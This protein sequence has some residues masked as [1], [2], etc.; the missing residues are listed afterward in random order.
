MKKKIVIIGGGIGGLSAGIY[1]LKAGYDA[2][3]YEK[4]PV[5]GGECMGWNRK[6]YHID[7]CIHWLT[8]TDEKTDLWKVWN[9]LGAIDENTAYVD[10]GKFY[11]SIL[12]GK[13]L[14]L[15]NDLEKTRNELIAFAPEDKKKILDILYPGREEKS[16]EETFFKRNAAINRRIKA[17][18]EETGEKICYKVIY[19][20]QYKQL[21]NTTLEFAVFRTREG[22]YNVVFLESQK[23]AIEA[24]LRGNAPTAHNRKLKL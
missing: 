8:G 20:N 15:W 13:E 10:E 4:N 3:I 21:R 9:T 16:S 23:Q 12:D 14:T 18:A 1:A 11:S 24:A 19:A 17:K 2:A 6:G 5:A 7:N 22:K